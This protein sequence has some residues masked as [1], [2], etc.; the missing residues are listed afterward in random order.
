MMKTLKELA[1]LSGV[2]VDTAHLMSNPPQIRNYYTFTEAQ[3]QVFAELVLIN[4][5]SHTQFKLDLGV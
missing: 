3:L 2:K 1:K 5:P 4:H